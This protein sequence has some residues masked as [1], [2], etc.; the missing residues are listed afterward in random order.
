MKDMPSNIVRSTYNSGHANNV[1]ADPGI[2]LNR[3]L[4]SEQGRKG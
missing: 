4:S 3:N 2:A 1:S